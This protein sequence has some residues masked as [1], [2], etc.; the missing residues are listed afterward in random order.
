M[1]GIQKVTPRTSR[2]A[3]A[4]A[5]AEREKVTKA[6]AKA[7]AVM[8]RD[9]LPETVTTVMSKDITPGT[10]LIPEVKS[11]LWK[12]DRRRGTRVHHRSHCV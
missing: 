8:P 3:L 12:K 2:K 9:H 1:I 11:E 7:R 4:R 6:K 5:K 10:A